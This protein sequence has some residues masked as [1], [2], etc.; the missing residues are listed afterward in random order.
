MAEMTEQ[1]WQQRLQEELKT[2]D[3]I[4]F[5]G[6]DRLQG[7]ITETKK[8]LKESPHQNQKRPQDIPIK[9]LTPAEMAAR[10]EKG[11]CYSCD[12]VYK[13]GHQCTKRQIFMFKEEEESNEVEEENTEIVVDSGG[14]LIEVPD[15]EDS[16]T[17]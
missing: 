11:L 16:A 6:I 17:R 15:P 1:P 12:E 9:R 4:V 7:I 5:R 14:K 3:M 10:R 13:F 2:L 8:E